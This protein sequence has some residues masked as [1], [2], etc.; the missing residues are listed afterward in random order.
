[1]DRK[2]SEVREL[3]EDRVVGGSRG[4]LLEVEWGLGTFSNPISFS[5]KA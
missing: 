5:C 1:M 4:N 2:G 3:I